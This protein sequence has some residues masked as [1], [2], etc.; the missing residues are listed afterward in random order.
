MRL[1][2]RYGYII[3]MMR[4][5][6][7][8]KQIKKR[9]EELEFPYQEWDENWYIK[10]GG[11]SKNEKALNDL[12]AKENDPLMNSLAKRKEVLSECFAALSDNELKV[13]KDVYINRVSNVETAANH[14]LYASKNY[15]YDRV[16]KPFFEQVELKLIS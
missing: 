11:F 15:A 10:A 13:I 6:P 3:N 2:T 7:F 9:I 12:I 4:E 8:D 14:Y 1:E 5:Y 16:I